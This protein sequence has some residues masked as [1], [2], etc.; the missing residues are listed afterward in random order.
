MMASRVMVKFL[1][2]DAHFIICAILGD[3]IVRELD[4]VF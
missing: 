4:R 2:E 3:F 1:L